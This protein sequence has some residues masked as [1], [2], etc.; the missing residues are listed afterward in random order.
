MLLKLDSHLHF[1]PNTGEIFQDILNRR[2]GEATRS[3][4][5]QVDSD[6][7]FVAAYQYCSQFGRFK[8]AFAYSFPKNR[9]FVLLEYETVDAVHEAFKY[10]GFQNDT[11]PWQ[12]RFLSLQ[13]E[14]INP[15]TLK[16]PTDSPELKF[17]SI[18][19]PS[20]QHLID[21][22]QKADTI[23]DQMQILY[24]NTRL[25]DL[26]IRLRFIGALQVQTVLS[27][28]LN[29]LFPN[30]TI[31]PFGSTMNGFG[32]MGCD[33]DMALQLKGIERNTHVNKEA[34]LLFHG[35]QYESTEEARKIEGKLQVKCV[36]SMI[37]YFLPGVGNVLSLHR[38][39]VPIVRYY[40]T[41]VL[42]NVDLSLNNL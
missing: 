21:V 23:D 13:H 32:K 5:V 24:E 9:H 28:F 6:K 22:L 38:A 20:S 39:R 27:Q 41:Y 35:K 2:Q 40:D 12:N 26:S 15:S 16:A 3:V 30:T 1:S 42:T 8:N 10:S 7:H 18:F 11:V 14:K 33:L 29:Y 25:D 19:E 36:G 17:N 31:Y 4:V 37:D 34:P